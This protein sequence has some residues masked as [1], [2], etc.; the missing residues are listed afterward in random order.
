MREENQRL[1]DLAQR[2][3]LFEERLSRVEQRQKTAGKQHA[4]A[5]SRSAP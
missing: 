2:L 3:R 4:S 1:S 5:P